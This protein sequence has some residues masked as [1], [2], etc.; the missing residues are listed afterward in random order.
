MANLFALLDATNT[1]INVTIGNE[2]DLTTE[3]EMATHLGVDVSKVKR[4]SEDGT[5]LNRG[6]ALIGGSY[7]TSG[8]YFIPEQRYSSWTFNSETR[9]WDAPVPEPTDQKVTHNIWWDEENQRWMGVV[10]GGDGTELTW[11]PD[12][13]TWENV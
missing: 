12:T 7:S 1:V 13:N 5:Y 6:E 9:D 11:N 3:Q 10:E 8:N 4:Y 2:T